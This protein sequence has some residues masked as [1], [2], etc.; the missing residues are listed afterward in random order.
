MSLSNRRLQQEA[1]QFHRNENDFITAGPS[2]DNLYLWRAVIFAPPDCPWTGGVFKAELRFPENYPMV[3]PEMRFTTPVYHP[4]VYQDGK[5]CISILHPPGDDPYGYEHASE[6]WSP[7]QSVESILISV[8]S[9]FS[10]PNFESPAN[11]D[12]AIQF[13][14]DKE[15]W[16]AQVQ[17]CVLHSQESL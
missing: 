17:Q 10:D 7:A 2:E 4:N 9:I 5:V 13:R 11:I 16:N 3:P 12:C 14:D 6:R 15:G 8:L 1:K